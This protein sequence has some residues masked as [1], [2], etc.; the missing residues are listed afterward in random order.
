MVSQVL[1]GFVKAIASSRPVCTLNFPLP[2]D[3]QRMVR[4]YSP[5]A[6]VFIHNPGFIGCHNDL[7]TILFGDKRNAFLY[8]TVADVG[9]QSAVQIAANGR[10]IGSICFQRAS[11]AL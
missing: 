2:P 7:P 5:S 10:R 6:K 8:D 1:D 3:L 9:H 11:N 4:M